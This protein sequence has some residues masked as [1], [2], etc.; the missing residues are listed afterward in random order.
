MSLTF[1][2]ETWELFRSS[3]P[4]FKDS[5]LFAIKD[6]KTIII[7]YLDDVLLM[8]PKTWDIQQHFI[9]YFF[10]VSYSCGAKNKSQE[11]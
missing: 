4:E 7:Y 3:H 11:I 8:T 5:K 9:L 6:L 10:L 2:I 1:S